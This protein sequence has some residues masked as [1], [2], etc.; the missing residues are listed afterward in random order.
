M[1]S[2]N[3]IKNVGYN[4]PPFEM[5]GHEL[6]GIK[7]RSTNKMKAFGTKDSD[8]PDKVSTTPGMPYAEGGVGSSPAKGFWDKVKRVGKGLLTGGLSEVARAK[9]KKEAAAAAAAEAGAAAG[10]GTV[11]P[12]GDEAHTGGGG[13]A[14]AVATGVG[15]GVGGELPAR[16]GDPIIDSAAGHEIGEGVAKE[17][18]V[19]K[20]WQGG[21]GEEDPAVQAVRTMSDMR[22]KEKIERTGKSPSG[23]PIY[24]FN[25]IG[26]SNRYSGVMA[27]DLLEM[28]IDA[29][30]LGEDGYYRVNYNNIDVDMRII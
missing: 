10:A 13:A 6:P 16:T 9:K 21:T 25:Y 8:M 14:G 4:Y 29:V 12:H 30:S 2:P 17:D 7:Q 23:I 15:G 19:K 5:K 22:A 18:V 20:P 27:Q 3:K 24:E 11:A 26:G 28:N 1:A